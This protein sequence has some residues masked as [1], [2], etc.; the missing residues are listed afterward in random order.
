VEGVH[1][2]VVGVLVQ[3]VCDTTNKGT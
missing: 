2:Q 1:Q 3:E